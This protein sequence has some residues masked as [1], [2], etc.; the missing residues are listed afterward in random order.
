MS[1]RLRSSR[2]DGT[3]ADMERER[4]K[5]QNYV[6]N[7]LEEWTRRCGDGINVKL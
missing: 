1:I 2:I 3:V 5:K 4:E 6:W 7:E